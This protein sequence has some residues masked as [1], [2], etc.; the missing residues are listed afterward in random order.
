MKNRKTFY[1]TQTVSRPRKFFSPSS[2]KISDVFWTKLYC[3]MSG[4]FCQFLLTLR[5]WLWNKKNSDDVHWNVWTKVVLEISFSKKE[6]Q[7]WDFEVFI[8]WSKLRFLGKALRRFSQC[9]FLFFIVDQPWWTTFFLSTP[10]IKNLPTVLG[11]DVLF[12]N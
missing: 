5:L 2:N 7:I 12:A 9:F 6:L 10:T 4:L 11:Y 8:F 1:K 3:K